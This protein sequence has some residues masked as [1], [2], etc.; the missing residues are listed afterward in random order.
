MDNVSDIL[1]IGEGQGDQL[2]FSVSTAGDVNND[3]YDDVLIGAHSNDAGGEKRGKAYLRISPYV[4]ADEGDELHLIGD[5]TDPDVGDTHTIEWDFGDGNTVTGNLTPF[6]AYG[7]DGVY[8]P[9]LTVTDNQGG[10]GS[11]SVRVM[12]NN[13]AP[14]AEAGGPYSGVVGIPVNIAGSCFDP[15]YLDTHTYTWDMDRNGYYGERTGATTSWTWNT[16]DTH[17]IMLM[18]IDDDGGVGYDIATVVIQSENRP[19]VADAGEDRTVY[20]GDVV[21][22]DGTTSFDPEGNSIE[23][24]WDFDAY[25]DSD[26][27]GDPTND[28]DAT[29]PTP[30]YIYGDDGVY[31]VSLTVVDHQGLSDTDTCNIT[32][33]NLDPT[34]AV[35]SATMEVEIGLRVAGRKYNDVGMALFEDGFPVGY[36]SMERIPGSPDAQMV[37]I[38]IT[39]DMT[40]TY[41]ATVTYMPEDPPNLG[42]NPVWIYIM[43]ENGSIKKIH[44]TFN[45]QQSMKRDSEHWN[46]VE[47][48]EVDINSFLIGYE[49]TLIANATD[50]GS[51]D[52]TFQWSFGKVTTYYN[53][54]MSPDPYPSPDG[55]FPFSAVDTTEHVYSGEETITLEVADDDGGITTTTLGLN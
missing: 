17:Y 22:F 31:T 8:D 30:S 12:V 13:V 28:I 24:S 26:G 53:N 40:K 20:E 34:A 33:L 41:T 42:S 51:D 14:V 10:V 46:H 21:Y 43:F 15:G 1:M 48:W 11:K 2:G 29:S 19:P 39:L 9:T 47:P 16:I 32:V 23:F 25:V 27:D 49:M 35:V 7:D 6:H 4:V 50:Q 44:H 38:P 3:G 36:V 18:V 55:V 37:W 45:I 5:F 54:G 52:L